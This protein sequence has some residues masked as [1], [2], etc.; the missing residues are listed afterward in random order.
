[1]RVVAL[2]VLSICVFSLV[3]CGPMSN[4][5][6]PPRLEPEQQKSVNDSWE[7]AVNPP[8]HLD[9]QAILDTLIL[10]QAY[11]L[12]VDRLSFH[13]EKDFSGGV[14]IMEI[15]FDRTKPKDDRFEV[16]IQ[17]KAGKKL[18]EIRYNRAE[19][20]LAFKDLH[21]AKYVNP[22]GPNDPP[23]DPEGV[24]RREEIQKRIAEVEKVFPKKD[25]AK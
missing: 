2:S 20:E 5:P 12:G 22:R 17:D 6:L 10:T 21:E 23:L 3:G 9:R 25:E 4:G 24:K 1:M 14:V 15:H 7:K 11:Q 18:R 16:T 13:S 19:V 8:D